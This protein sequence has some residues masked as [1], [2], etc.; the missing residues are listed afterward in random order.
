MKA[1][2]NDDDRAYRV[3]PLIAHAGP[4]GDIAVPLTTGQ[5]GG[6][7]DFNGF[8]VYVQITSMSA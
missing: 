5:R 1:E 3:R 6:G 4:S 2:F 7:A 8:T